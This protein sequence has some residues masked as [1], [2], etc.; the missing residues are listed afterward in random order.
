[1]EEYRKLFKMYLNDCKRRYDPEE[2]YKNIKIC[3][4]ACERY[5]NKLDGMLTLL[6][7]QEVITDKEAEKEFDKLIETFSTLSLFNATMEEGEVFV[8]VKRDALPVHG[9]E[10]RK[11]R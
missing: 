4:S 8:W 5:R 1:M 3:C 2:P 7:A 6:Q 11:P 10:V 9:G